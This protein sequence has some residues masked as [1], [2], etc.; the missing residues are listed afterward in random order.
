MTEYLEAKGEP[1]EEEQEVESIK[2]AAIIFLNGEIGHQHLAICAE[3]LSYHYSDYQGEIQLLINSDGGNVSTGWAIVDTMNFIRVPVR[4]VALG[5][6]A[7]MAA[8]IFSNGDYRVIGEHSTLMVH[9]HSAGRGGSY[10][11]LLAASKM[12]EIEHNRRLLHYLNNSNYD[13]LEEVEENL[14]STRGDDLFL[15]PK[16]CLEHGLCDEIAKSDK[17]KRRKEYRTYLGPAGKPIKV[18]ARGRRKKS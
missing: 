2:E 17:T 3:L 12:D 16:E 7:S 8:D 9:P 13:T 15:T 18:G 11:S 14:F 6:C 5:I 10:S 1:E 4:T